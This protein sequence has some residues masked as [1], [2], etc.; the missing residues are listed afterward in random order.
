M[1]KERLSVEDQSDVQSYLR[2]E[3]AKKEKLIEEQRKENEVHSYIY[4]MYAINNLEVHTVNLL[5]SAC[6]QYS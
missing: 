2:S 6:V 3:I 1:I 4:N 5:P